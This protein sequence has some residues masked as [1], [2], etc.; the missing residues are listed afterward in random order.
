MEIETL[1]R[2]GYLDAASCRDKT[3]VLRALHGF[4]DNTLQ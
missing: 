2:R 1:A 4:L 3:A